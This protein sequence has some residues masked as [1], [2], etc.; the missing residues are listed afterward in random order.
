MHNSIFFF[1]GPK[2]KSHKKDFN[3]LHLQQDTAVT[4]TM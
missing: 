1:E 3:S 2:T 4:K